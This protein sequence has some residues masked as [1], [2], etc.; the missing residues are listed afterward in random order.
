MNEK[1]VRY[2]TILCML[3]AVT[4]ML[5][6]QLTQLPP[7]MA[8]I[9]PSFRAPPRAP[10]QPE[11]PLRHELAQCVDLDRCWQHCDPTR[12]QRL[13]PCG[14]QGFTDPVGPG[15]HFNTHPAGCCDADGRR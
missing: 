12:Y 5:A 4:C 15:A 2:A 9:T 13:E 10:V 6:V 1:Y 11:R 8:P 7:S 14:W 3:C